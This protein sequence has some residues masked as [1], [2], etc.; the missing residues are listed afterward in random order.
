MY[1]PAFALH[2]E[3][4]LFSTDA[5]G[6]SCRIADGAGR[7]IR[8]TL[9]QGPRCWLGDMTSARRSLKGIDHTFEMSMSRIDK[10]RVVNCVGFLR[11]LVQQS[12]KNLLVKDLNILLC[13]PGKQNSINL[14]GTIASQVLLS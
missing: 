5:P 10:T 12:T 1:F 13:Q 8:W 3:P 9:M 6:N 11:S 4:L 7:S 14:F 2:C